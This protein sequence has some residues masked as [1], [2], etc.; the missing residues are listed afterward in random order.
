MTVH[1]SL[2]A[3]VTCTLHWGKDRSRMRSPLSYSKQVRSTGGEVVNA[4]ACK[5]GIRGFE[6]HPGAPLP[7]SWGASSSRA[8]SG[9]GNG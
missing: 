9:H 5:A 8:L 3:S 7:Y 1:V 6:S 4:P 2:A